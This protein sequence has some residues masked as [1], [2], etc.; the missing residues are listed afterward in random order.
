[1]HTDI[2]RIIMHYYPKRVLVSPLSDED[3]V[4]DFDT[5]HG[6]LN[7]LLRDLTEIGAD[8]R[9]GT[10][11]AYDV[12]EEVVLADGLRLQLCSIG[13]YAAIDYE[14]EHTL[15]ADE[16]AL[17]E[18][19]GEVLEKHGIALLK[20]NDLDETV[21][22]IKGDPVRLPATVWSCLFVNDEYRAAASAGSGETK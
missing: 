10:R 19:V 16:Q 13:P 11:G 20:K 3:I 6:T 2:E 12:S 21:P 17:V 18:R 4:W 1:M 5:N 15:D 22:W 7:A 14:A 9:P 8:L